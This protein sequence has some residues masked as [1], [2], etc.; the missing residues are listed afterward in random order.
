MELSKRLSKIFSLVE[1]TDIVAD[2]GCDHGYIAISLIEKKICKK[3]IAMDINQGPLIS[4]SKNII[5]RGFQEEIETRLSNGFEKLGS[6]EANT[7]ILAGMGGKL[8]CSILKVVEDKKKQYDTLILQ[9]QSMIQSVRSLIV[10]LG[11]EIDQEV[12][13]LDEGKYY[14][15]MRAKY[16][17][18]SS[19]TVLNQVELKYGRILLL[20]KDAILESFLK[21][22]KKVC[23]TIFNNLKEEREASFQKEKR[24]K[25]LEKKISQINYALTYYE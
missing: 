7:V 23:E 10:S 16:M 4:A 25:E 24:K 19:K 11:Y 12:A 9:P 1:I 3:V 14:F 18:N 21:K 5:K 22:E 20:R 6:K 15:A 8:I 13:V 17:S 2:I